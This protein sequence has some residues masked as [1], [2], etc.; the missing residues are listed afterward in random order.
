VDLEIAIYFIAKTQSVLAMRR[1]VSGLLRRFHQL[2][3]TE[4]QKEHY[5][6]NALIQ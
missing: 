3:I 1:E 4:V 5:T 6:N 2:A